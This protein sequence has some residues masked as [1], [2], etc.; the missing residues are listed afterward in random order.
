MKHRELNTVILAEVIG[1]LILYVLLNYVAIHPVFFGFSPVGGDAAG[2]AMAKGFGLLFVLGILFLIALAL[3]IVNYF[4][5]RGVSNWAIRS[6]SFVPIL[7]S[8][9]H[10]LYTI[11][12]D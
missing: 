10:I 8:V 12:L 6:L 7:I 11:I 9:A 4:I 5:L 2:N 3:T 1:Y